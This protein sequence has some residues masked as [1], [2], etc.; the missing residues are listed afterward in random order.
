MKMYSKSMGAVG[1]GDPTKMGK[2]SGLCR[3]GGIGNTEGPD[4]REEP[5]IVL[6]PFKRRGIL[7]AHRNF[8]YF[9]DKKG[10]GSSPK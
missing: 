5:I 10:Y 6:L 7:P 1:D 3:G 4:D 9:T 8:G 2:V